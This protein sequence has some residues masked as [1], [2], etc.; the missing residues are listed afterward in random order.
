[1]LAVEL[2][3]NA[4]M[5]L[6]EVAGCAEGPEMA[7]TA[8]WAQQLLASPDR[9][10]S[11]AA[12]VLGALSHATK[13]CCGPREQEEKLR[14]AEKAIRDVV[15]CRVQSETPFG[16]RSFFVEA[17]QTA[18]HWM[19]LDKETVLRSQLMHSHHVI[20]ADFPGQFRKRAFVTPRGPT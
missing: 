9:R 7:D 19:K 10:P 2:E 18:F 5:V 8:R 14:D 13:C 17:L 11:N 6:E 16:E 1:M 15:V 12:R 4:W 20:F 3:L